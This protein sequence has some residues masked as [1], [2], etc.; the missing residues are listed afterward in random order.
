MEALPFPGRQVAL[1]RQGRPYDRRAYICSHENLS[2]K[3]GPLLTQLQLGQPLG[4]GGVAGAPGRLVERLRLLR[5]REGR[6]V[7]DGGVE[8]LRQGKER[9]RV[10]AGPEG[11]QEEPGRGNVARGHALARVLHGEIDSVERYGN[12][13]YR[14]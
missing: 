7:R 11:F 14:P 9:P 10:A 4:R 6:I 8:G 13:L 3:T 12:R 1:P 5:V 2:R